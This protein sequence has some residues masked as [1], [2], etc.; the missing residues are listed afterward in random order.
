MTPEKA[1]VGELTVVVPPADAP[2]L[3]FEVEPAAPPVPKLTVFVV[4]VAV[5]FVE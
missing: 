5:A 1:A 4:A 2:M 3:I